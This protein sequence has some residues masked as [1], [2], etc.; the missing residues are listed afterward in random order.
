MQDI[1]PYD[2]M[3][4]ELLGVP[5]IPFFKAAPFELGLMS[6]RDMKVP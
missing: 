5:D 4:P 3:P 6:M 2:F 1:L